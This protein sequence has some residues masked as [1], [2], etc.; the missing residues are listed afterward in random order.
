MF[1][2]YFGDRF[3]FDLGRNWVGSS[4][5]RFVV[6]FSKFIVKSCVEGFCL[7]FGG[8]VFKDMEGRG[9]VWVFVVVVGVEFRFGVRFGGL[10][11]FDFRG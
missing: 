10:G 11:K 9:F 3:F 1:E 7:D 8:D 2:C 6:F 5:I 4:C